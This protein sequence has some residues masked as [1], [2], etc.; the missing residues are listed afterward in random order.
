MLKSNQKTLFIV[1]SL[2]DSSRGFS[3]QRNKQYFARAEGLR[4]LHEK[5]TKLLKSTELSWETQPLSLNLI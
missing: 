2:T 4:K 5:K 3:W 1:K